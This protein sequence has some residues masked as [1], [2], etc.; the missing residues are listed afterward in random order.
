MKK[1]YTIEESKKIADKIRLRVFDHV[2]KNNGGYLS[3]ACSSAEMF[4]AFI[5]T[6][7]KPE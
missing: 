7:S 5:Y 1:S 2:L 6:N 4:S 3:Q